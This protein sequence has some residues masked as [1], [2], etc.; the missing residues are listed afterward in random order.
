MEVRS[1]SLCKRSMP[2]LLTPEKEHEV[3]R[4]IEDPTLFAQ[5][6]LGHDVWSKQHE[7]LQSVAM[8]PRTAVK[9]CHASGKSFTA[10]ELALWWV[11]SHLEGIAVTTAPTW[12]QVERV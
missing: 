9:A 4:I 2:S 8:H 10:A 12:T 7:I 5:V 6:M 11:T 1:S 3:L